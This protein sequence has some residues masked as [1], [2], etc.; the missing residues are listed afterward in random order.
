MFRL[1]F[2][3]EAKIRIYQIIAG[4][5]ALNSVSF[6]T[7][8]MTSTTTVSQ[9]SETVLHLAAHLLSLDKDELT[10]ILTTRSILPKGQNQNAII[11]NMNE[12][13]AKSAK[14]V[15]VKCLYVKLHTWIVR[16]INDMISH[17]LA[18]ETEPHAIG[19]LDMPGFGTN[20]LSAKILN[21]SLIFFFNA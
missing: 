7:N 2:D 14:D 20:F 8:E 12:M 6:E 3:A 4:M 16:K 21:S 13:Q 11:I 5:F 17:Q 18:A 1:G 9:S 19:L 15:L 10:N